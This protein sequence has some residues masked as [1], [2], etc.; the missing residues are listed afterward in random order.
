MQKSPITILMQQHSSSLL[1]VHLRRLGIDTWKGTIWFPY[2]PQVATLPHS[3]LLTVSSEN[4]DAFTYFNGKPKPV[5]VISYKIY[6]HHKLQE[7]FL[8]SR[9]ITPFSS[10]L[11]GI[12]LTMLIHFHWSF[13]GTNRH[14]IWILHPGYFSILNC[15]CYKCQSK[16]H[17][18]VTLKIPNT[19]NI[20]PSGNGL[21]SLPFYKFFSKSKWESCRSQMNWHHQLIF[22]TLKKYW[23]VHSRLIIL[24][25]QY[26]PTYTLQFRRSPFLYKPWDLGLCLFSWDTMERN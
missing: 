19:I 14:S 20:W 22:Q 26:S 2:Q 15:C 3:K 25:I 8:F 10:F 6:S 23:C 11:E 18:T 1:P 12:L 21:Y 16:K 13:C 7:R 17:C 5:T 9:Q 4:S 24:I